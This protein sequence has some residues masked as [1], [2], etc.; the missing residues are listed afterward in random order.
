MDKHGINMRM[1]ATMNMIWNMNEYGRD[2]G[3]NV[4]SIMDECAMMEIFVYWCI[5]YMYTVCKDKF[6]Y[7]TWRWLRKQKQPQ[8]LC[9]TFVQWTFK[10]KTY[11]QARVVWTS[12]SV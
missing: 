9:H 11:S 3:I 7:M 4:V 2:Y 1:N 10:K 5:W 6:V 8:T 12:F